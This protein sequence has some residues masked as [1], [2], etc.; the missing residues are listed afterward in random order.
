MI[1]NLF[2]GVMLGFLILGSAFRAQA[3]DSFEA[4][5]KIVYSKYAFAFTGTAW[6]SAQYV[7]LKYEPSLEGERRY[8]LD[9][10]LNLGFG[11]QILGAYLKRNHRDFYESLPKGLR[12]LFVISPLL[13]LDDAWQHLNQLHDG[14]K[15]P[16]SSR[17]GIYRSPLHQFYWN[18]VRL[19]EKAGPWKVG[20]NVFD[21]SSRLNMSVGFFQGIFTG[22]NFTLLQK[23]G[24]TWAA[25][26]NTVFINEV[27]RWM[28]FRKVIFGS[29]LRKR[30]LLNVEL[31]IGAGLRYGLSSRTNYQGK[32]GF[33]Y[34]IGTNL[35]GS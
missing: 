11:L 26:L 34:W 18:S 9:H 5:E 8:S 4:L 17:A 29:S 1:R 2:L 13:T 6:A 12:F 19:D 3:Q 7:L 16:G 22:L 14:Y 10:H 32:M 28:H 24:F 35:F 23:S 27:K 31:E 30:M 21:F 15:G 33:T 25:N 20:V